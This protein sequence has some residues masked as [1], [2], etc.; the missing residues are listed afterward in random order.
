MLV[1]VITREAQLEQL[2]REGQEG[3]R[4][5][6]SSSG[7]SVAEAKGSASE[8]SGQQAANSVTV[9]SDSLRARAHAGS[10]LSAAVCG[11]GPGQP[12][13][14]PASS[15][16]QLSDQAPHELEALP[17]AWLVSRRSDRAA[18]EKT[19]EAVGVDNSRGNGHGMI[20][21][22]LCSLD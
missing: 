20:S 6:R 1:L 11:V 9:A 19:T 22:R 17:A 14:H 7:K 13:T 21:N 12:V 4:G 8:T 15:L 16:H 3:F 2:V 5:C 18:A 10:P